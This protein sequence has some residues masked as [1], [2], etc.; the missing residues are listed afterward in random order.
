MDALLSFT[1]HGVLIYRYPSNARTH[2]SG[3]DTGVLIYRYPSNARTHMSGKD[4][5]VLMYRY[6]SNARTHMS[7]KDTGVLIYRYPSNA[8]THMSGKDT[9]FESA[10]SEERYPFEQKCQCQEDKLGLSADGGT[11]QA[12]RRSSAPPS[13]SLG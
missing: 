8:R 9:E 1:G 3:K 4:T 6:S 2:M 13:A 5:G 10:S 11:V 12:K 7:G